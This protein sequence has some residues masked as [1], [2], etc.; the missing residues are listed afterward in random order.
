MIDYVVLVREFLLEQGFVAFVMCHPADRNVMCI[1]VPRGNFEDFEAANVYVG[2]SGHL[3]EINNP[4]F[5]TLHFDLT[6]P[7]SLESIVTAIRCYSK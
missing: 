5:K 1:V 6:E 7:D 3:V 2:V 4:P